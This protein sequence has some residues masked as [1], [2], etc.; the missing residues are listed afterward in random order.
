[1]GVPK[2]RRTS[3]D[4]RRRASHFAMNKQV[5]GECKKCKSP[6]RPHYACGVCG[7]YGG[8]ES[9]D[10][11]R[12]VARALKKSQA[13]LPPQDTNPEAPKTTEVK[14]KDEKVK[15]SKA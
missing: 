9:I 10:M 7:T 5:L 13:T 2:H 6:V 8:R 4:K 1:M 11:S 15:S 3:G 12:S 14:K